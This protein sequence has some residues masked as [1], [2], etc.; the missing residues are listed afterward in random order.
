MI[1]FR[2]LLRLPR[3][4]LTTLCRRNEILLFSAIRILCVSETQNVTCI[5]LADLA[6]TLG[7]RLMVFHR[8]P[9][10]FH[11]V[12]VSFFRA[13]DGC[14]FAGYPESTERHISCGISEGT[15]RFGSRHL[16][17]LRSLLPLSRRRHR[18]TPAITANFN[19]HF[20]RRDH[21]ES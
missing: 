10:T 11:L 7:K 4:Q 15:G 21:D 13:G 18:T 6:S 2:A 16:Q 17:T 9:A 14:N 3:P 8:T 12:I 20:L 1:V 19:P 5:K